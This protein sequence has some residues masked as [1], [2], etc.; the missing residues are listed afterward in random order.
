MINLLVAGRLSGMISRTGAEPFGS[1]KRAQSYSF[2]SLGNQNGRLKISR[3][4]S[5]A[6]WSWRRRLLL[7]FV[8]V[9]IP[10]F[11]WTRCGCRRS[12]PR[13]ML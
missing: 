8:V 3:V 5:R 13:G 2:R 4:D 10:G 6:C 7:Y 12:W 11:N 1:K 9:R